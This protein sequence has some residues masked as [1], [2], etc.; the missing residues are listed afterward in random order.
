MSRGGPY[1]P[2]PVMGEGGTYHTERVRTKRS[3]AGQTAGVRMR[4]VG[5]HPHAEQWA[6]PSS[7]GRWEPCLRQ[8]FI[9]S[10]SML[11]IKQGASPRGFTPVGS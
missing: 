1:H 9:L 10:F 4:R 6:Y 8:S 2:V 7:A 11:G 5:V 3:R